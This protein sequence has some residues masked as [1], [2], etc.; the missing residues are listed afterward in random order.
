MAVIDCLKCA[1]IEGFTE[2]QV[3]K[4]VL[5]GSLQERVLKGSACPP[6]W[7][8]GARSARRA[9][10][11]APPHELADGLA[12]VFVVPAEAINPANNERVAGAEQIEQAAPL[13]SFA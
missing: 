2:L 9:S 6:A 3:L 4:R 7:E 11:D 12:D 8:T 5:V 1:H 13:R 10:D